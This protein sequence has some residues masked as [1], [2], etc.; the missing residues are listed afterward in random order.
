MKLRTPA[1]GWGGGSPDGGFRIICLH[2]L[3][4]PY[5]FFTFRGLRDYGGSISTRVRLSGALNSHRHTVGLLYE[6]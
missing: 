4:H 5:P 1:G 2:S 3:K 6:V